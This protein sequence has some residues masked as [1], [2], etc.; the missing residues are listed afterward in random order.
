MAS[1][2]AYSWRGHQAHA[3]HNQALLDYFIQQVLP[4]DPVF[5]DWALV[6][7]FY[8]AL[9][10]TKAAI[11]R[12]HGVMVPKHRSG[13][14]RGGKWELGHND[15]V[16]THLPQI[17][18]EYRDLFD[19]GVQARYEGFFKLGQNVLLE[20]VRQ[21]AELAKIKAGCEF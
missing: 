7:C 6:V 5:A 17:S 12:D 21:Q 16:R 19:I 1:N 20:V 9:H 13:P 15:L 8:A 2:P 10:Y 3:E 18:A 11:L 14:G 4:R